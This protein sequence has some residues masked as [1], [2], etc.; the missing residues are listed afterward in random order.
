MMEMNKC[1]EW[2]VHS[3]YWAFTYILALQVACSF[4]CSFCCDKKYIL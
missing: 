3:V 1:G 4:A 2:A